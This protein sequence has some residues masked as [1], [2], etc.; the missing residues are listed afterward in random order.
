MGEFKINHWLHPPSFTYIN[1]HYAILNAGSGLSA[2]DYMIDEK[3]KRVGTQLD[4]NDAEQQ[5][6]YDGLYLD[7]QS[8]PVDGIR[9]WGNAAGGAPQDYEE[10]RH[11]VMQARIRNMGNFTA[12]NVG[13]RR[14]Y[15]YDIQVANCDTRGF[16]MGSGAGDSVVIDLH[17]EEITGGPG[18]MVERGF[19][20][21]IRPIAQDI[22]DDG[23]VIGKSNKN[24]MLGPL[25]WGGY[26][27]FNDGIG[28]RVRDGV[29]GGTID[30][31]RAIT[32]GMATDSPSI[33]T[34]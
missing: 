22:Q 16:V 34:N 14:G 3:E 12:F 28:L 31:M 18:I 8:D 2:G 26:T 25:I 6:H 24:E 5:I 27:E 29:K 10:F 20:H 32:N 17:V 13:T 15:Y 30:G 33:Q 4:P 21:V 23:I 7:G 9:T 19:I 1:G 11:G